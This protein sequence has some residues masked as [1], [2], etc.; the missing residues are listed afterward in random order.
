MIKTVEEI[1][2]MLLELIGATINFYVDGNFIHIYIYLS[3]YLFNPS[4]V[5]SFI[6]VSLTAIICNLCQLFSS[7]FVHLVTAHS[8]ID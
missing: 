8:F 5:L 4:I 1:V 2:V 6:L 3:I 7:W